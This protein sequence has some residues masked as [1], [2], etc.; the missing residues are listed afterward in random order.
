MLLLLVGSATAVWAVLQLC[1]QVGRIEALLPGAS[2]AQ[3]M[4]AGDAIFEGAT[5]WA[6]LGT[7]LAQFHNILENSTM[8]AAGRAAAEMLVLAQLT[9]WLNTSRRP[10]GIS[11]A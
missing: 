3:L 11:L 6:P 4:E 7:R 9:L 10:S 5:F 2:V 1:G 8:H